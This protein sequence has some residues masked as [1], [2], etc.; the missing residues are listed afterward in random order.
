VDWKKT[1]PNNNLQL[2]SVL[3]YIWMEFDDIW[4]NLIHCVRRF[5][6]HFA[7]FGA[8]LISTKPHTQRGKSAIASATVLVFHYNQCI[9]TLDSI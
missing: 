9:G 7:E 3:R 6:Y 1:F 2:D 4:E 5:G 8:Y